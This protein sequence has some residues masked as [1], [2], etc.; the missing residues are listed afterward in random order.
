[1]KIRTTDQAKCKRQIKCD[2][3][4]QLCNKSKK[5]IQDL[6]VARQLTRNKEKNRRIHDKANAQVWEPHRLGVG[7]INT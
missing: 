5:N 2:S 6:P 4:D 1:M 3:E 7:Q